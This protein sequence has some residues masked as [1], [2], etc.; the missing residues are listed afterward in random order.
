MVEHVISLLG[1]TG[2][3]GEQTIDVARKHGI[4]IAALAAGSNIER[5]YEQALE[6]HPSLVAVGDKKKAHQ[7]RERLAPENIRVVAGEDG[8]CEAATVREADMV[9]TAVVGMIGL[10]PTLEA[11]KCCKAIALAN[12]ETLVAGG[13]LVM[14]AVEE[15][16]VPILPVDSEHSAI[17]QSMLGCRDRK[18]I[19]SILLTASGGPFFGKKRAQLKNITP[20]DAVKHPNWNMGRKISVDSATL[21]NKGLELIEAMH[22]FH[23]RPEQIQVI[24]HRESIIHSM[25][26]Y[27]DGCVMA[28][29]SSPD[30]RL[31]IQLALTYPERRASDLKPLDLIQLKNLSFAEPDRETFPAL[32][33]CRRA[34]EQGGTVPAALNGANEAAVAFFLDGKIPFLAI[35]TLLEKFLQ[36]YDRRPVQSLEDV[37][38]ADQTGR[39]FIENYAEEYKFL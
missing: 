24:V 15:K 7:L 23:V 29:L 28:Q 3:I 33:L 38:K 34:A 5:L 4:K 27:V 35:D 11:I 12:K 37:L 30:M 17:F 39:A 26:E 25:V 9:L 16:K 13:D 18:E 22:L 2:S 32:E 1:S 20:Q 19:R 21:M 8:L 31:P 6:F 36:Q 14:R 10:R